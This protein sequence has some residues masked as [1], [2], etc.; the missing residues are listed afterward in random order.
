MKLRLKT[1]SIVASFGIGLTLA[2]W[3]IPMKEPFIENDWK[4]AGILIFTIIKL[5]TQMIL[6]AMEDFK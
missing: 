3:F 4:T 5:I 6:I 2:V 1:I